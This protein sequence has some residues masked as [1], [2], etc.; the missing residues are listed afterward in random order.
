MK[1]NNW[2]EYIIILLILILI[3]RLR[4][5]KNKNILN[6]TSDSIIYDDYKF[7]DYTGERP[8]R[9]IDNPKNEMKKYNVIFG[10]T[11]RNVEKYMNNNFKYI[12]QCGEKFNDY[13]LI[14]YEN[15]STD[16]TR[17]I[18][19]KNKKDN[20]IYLFE[21]NVKEELRTMRIANGRNK[22]LEKIRE[23][24]KNNYYN[25]LVMIDLDD[26][27]QNGQYVNTIETCFEYSGWDVLTGNQSSNYY[28]LW[29]LRKKGDMEYDGWK[30]IR[31]NKHISYAGNRFLWSKY[32]QY[33]KG[34]L[35]EIDSGFSGI[36]IY[37]LKS[38]PDECVYVGKY[39]D[40]SDKCEHVEFNRCIKKSGSNIYINTDFLT[41]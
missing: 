20:Y 39:E 1:K 35:L 38:V 15:D 7:I 41:Y 2:I 13:L 33:N 29:A 37:K 32:K 12:T 18:L 17:D 14:I 9:N 40:G 19:L 28:D 23:I 3:Y 8:I 24:N 36:A 21:D 4:F 31:M 30:M 10:S 34:E 6:Y 16:A 11:I 26:I 25:Y 5:I 22:I 27:N